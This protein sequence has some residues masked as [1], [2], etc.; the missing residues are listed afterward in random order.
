MSVPIV[1]P[2]MT[3]VELDDRAMARQFEIST[4][5]HYQITAHGILGENPSHLS[6]IEANAHI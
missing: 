3:M 2:I 5:T 4:P 1:M 6:C